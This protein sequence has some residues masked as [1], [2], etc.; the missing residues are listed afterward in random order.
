MIDPQKLDPERLSLFERFSLGKGNHADIDAGACAMEMVSYIA[1]EPF[2]DHPQ[3]ACPVLT[4]FVIAWNDALS[5][6]DRNRIIKPFV[7]KLIGTRSTRATEEARSYLALDWYLRVM[8]PT[9]LELVE[10]L[11]PHAEAMRSAAPVVDLETAEAFAPLSAAAGA[12]ARAAA[13]DA[14]RDAAW[15]AA[16]AAAGDAA[17]AALRPTVERLQASAMQLLDRMIALA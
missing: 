5:D 16:R 4:S 17:W 2:S 14:A 8:T 6:E 3:C 1:G 10:T 12:A 11:K 15:A 7:P 13:W 9:W